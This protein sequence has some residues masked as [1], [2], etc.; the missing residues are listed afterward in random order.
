MRESE[1]FQKHRHLLPHPRPR[2]CEQRSAIL[3]NRGPTRLTILGRALGYQT[4]TYRLKPA[5]KEPRKSPVTYG[6]REIGVGLHPGR[7]KEGSFAHKK[8]KKKKK[9][10][11]KNPPLRSDGERTKQKSPSREEHLDTP[12]TQGHWVNSV[13]MSIHSSV[14]PQGTMV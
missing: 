1:A 8:K 7:R 5:Q 12:M 11:G 4:A 3:M 10:K 2:E 6:E 14:Y 13:N 9:T